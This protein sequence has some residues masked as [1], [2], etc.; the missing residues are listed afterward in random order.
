[1]YTI[2]NL[3]DASELHKRD[4]SKKFHSFSNVTMQT[5]EILL[6]ANKGIK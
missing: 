2:L 1:M 3:L 4:F 6:K 5:F